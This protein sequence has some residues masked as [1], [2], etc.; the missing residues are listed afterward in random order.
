MPTPLAVVPPCFAVALFEEVDELERADVEPAVPEDDD[1]PPQAARTKAP[2]IRTKAR[3]R[4]GIGL[5][6]RFF[7]SRLK[8]V[9]SSH[10]LHTAT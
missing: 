6:V 7:S 4:L 10:G 3:T 8:P 1:P 2:A 5:L 9:S